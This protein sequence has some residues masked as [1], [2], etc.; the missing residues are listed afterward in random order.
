M[1]SFL[2]W[3]P[4]CFRKYFPKPSAKDIL[5]L[6]VIVFACLNVHTHLLCTWSGKVVKLLCSLKFCWLYAINNFWEWPICLVICVLS[7]DANWS[8][9]KIN[10]ISLSCCT[11]CPYSPFPNP[12]VIQ[13]LREYSYLDRVS[14]TTYIYTCQHHRSLFKFFSN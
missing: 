2:F 3:S 12:N 14:W 6:P 4:C 1:A 13:K 7:L 8:L 10:I 11:T 9:C 5:G